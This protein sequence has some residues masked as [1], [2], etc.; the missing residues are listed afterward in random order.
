MATLSAYRNGLTVGHG[1]GNPEPPPRGEITGWTAGT[2][3]R[4]TRW[5]YSVNAPELDGHGYALTLTLRDCPEDA[6]TWQALRRAWVERQRRSDLVRM[7]WVVEWQRRG[8]PHMHVAVYF[9]RELTGAERWKPL[10]D[11]LDVA[12]A[13]G[14]SWRSQD[15]KPIDGAVGWLQYLS[16]H[17]ARGVS[18]YQRWAKPAGWTKTGRLWGHVGDWPTLEP[19]SFDLDRSEFW[20]LRRLIRRWRVRDAQAALSAARTPEAARA[21][22]R[23]IVSARRMLACSNRRLSEVRGC[24]EWIDDETATELFAE[25]VERAG[26]ALAVRMAADAPLDAYAPLVPEDC[27]GTAHADPRRLA[28]WA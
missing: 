11:W 26:A 28:A 5:L 16:K 17:A 10:Q 19:L 7:H 20:A 6:A 15:V 9:S 21:A 27:Q 13:Y 4:H 8:V 1:G 3:R 24:S 12:S 23:R 2:V 14:A 25:A 22:R 18:H